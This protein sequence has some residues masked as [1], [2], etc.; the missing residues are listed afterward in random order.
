MLR[1]RIHRTD[2]RSDVESE[3][4]KISK[5]T[6]RFFQEEVGWQSHSGVGKTEVGTG[7]R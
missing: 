5:M 3:E 7:F 4:E 6:S 2:D 1:N